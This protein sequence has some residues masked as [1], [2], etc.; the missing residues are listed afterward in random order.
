M[1]GLMEAPQVRPEEDR[2]P[3]AVRYLVDQAQH[4]IDRADAKASTLAATAT[5]IVAIVAQGTPWLVGGA[6]RPGW[7]VPL[8]GGGLLAWVA[9]IVALAL[10][11]FPRFRRTEGLSGQMTFFHDF[12]QEYDPEALHDQARAWEADP[13]RPLLAQAHALSRIA[14]TKYRMIQIG[15]ALLGVGGLLGVIG[16]FFG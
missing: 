14:V 1:S 12:P 6:Q 11:I 16:I 8:L 7:A 15:M 2:T 10:A 9:G 13:E 5:A 4:A 3:V